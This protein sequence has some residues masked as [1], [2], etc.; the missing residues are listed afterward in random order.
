MAFDPNC[1]FNERDVEGK[2]IIQYL[3]PELGFAPDTW[4]RERTFDNIRLDFL[5]F[6]NR[7]VSCTDLSQEK[8]CLI[9]ETKHPKQDLERH[10][11]QLKEYLNRLGVEFGLLTNGREI[12]IYKQGQNILDLLFRCFGREVHKNIGLIREIIGSEN[13]SLP[14]NIPIGTENNRVELAEV[15]QTQHNRNEFKEWGQKMKVIAIYHNKGGVEKTTVSVNLAA[16]LQNKGKRVLLVDIDA[17]ANST[18][19][20]GLIKFQFNE[21]DDL[22]DSNVYHIIESKDFNSI[23][24]IKRQS[25]LFNS[26]EIDVIPSHIDLIEQQEKLTKIAASRFRLHHKIQQAE[27]DYDI[28]IID[29]PPSRDVYA[30]IALIAADY[31]IIPSDLKP[32]ANQGLA[33]V[34]SFIQDVNEFRNDMGKE[35]L[36]VIGVLPSKILSNNKYLEF[37]FP[38]QKQT[39]LEHYNFPVMDNVIY[40]RTALSNCINKTITAGI[41]TLPD[42]KS[43]FAFDS[44]ADSVREFRNLATE[45]LNKISE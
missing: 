12:R 45:V 7:I 22:K 44:D 41:H 38:K 40:E 14:V 17:Q 28:V 11:S 20:T 30:E 13:L 34:Q 27:D 19:A 2:L 37:V 36:K 9:I 6:R 25:Q 26:P 42:P 10:V 16:A 8:P 31:L 33:N 35:K 39:I 3:L 23:S 21:D 18:F 1:C 29:A 4:Y 43:I 24:E 5:A 15:N 32:F